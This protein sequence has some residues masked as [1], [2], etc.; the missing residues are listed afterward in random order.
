LSHIQLFIRLGYRL[1]IKLCGLKVRAN[2]EK[3]KHYDRLPPP[4]VFETPE[5]TEEGRP[6]AIKNPDKLK[7]HWDLRLSSF[8]KLV[9]VKS[10]E[11]EQVGYIN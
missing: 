4:P 6:P 8:Q 5:E 3:W 1:F 2:P 7:G 10:F 9:F 11:E